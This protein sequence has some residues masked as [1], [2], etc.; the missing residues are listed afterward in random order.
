M[1]YCEQHLKK[2]KGNL[3]GEIALIAAGIVLV[4]FGALI[5]A[6]MIY[7]MQWGNIVVFGMAIG[8]ILAAL[9]VFFIV[10]ASLRRKKRHA[11]EDNIEQSELVR[12]IRSLLPPEHANRTPLG[13]FHL[14]DQDLA[15]GKHFGR[16]DV[17]REWVLI[18]ERALR[19]E[20][21]LGIFL[22]KRVHTSSKVTATLYE[23]WVYDHSFPGA[24]LVFPVRRMAENCYQAL[25]EAA[26]HAR[27]GGKKEAEAFLKEMQSLKN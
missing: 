16:A 6:A 7:A 3:A 26:P 5:I 4:L 14:V 25:I 2:E 15:K 12:S 1:S 24:N 23:L 22:Y 20:Q 27:N 10:Y 21:I 9:G 8:L 18:G 17:G 13:L 11:V 19:T